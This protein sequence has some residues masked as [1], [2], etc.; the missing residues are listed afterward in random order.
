MTETSGRY[1]RNIG[2]VEICMQSHDIFLC[3]KILEEIRHNLLHKIKVPERTVASILALLKNR[4]N[5][6]EPSEIE[7]GLCRDECDRMVL[8]AAK[9]VSPRQ[10]WEL[11]KSAK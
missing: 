3:D 2:T 10:F 1:D 7:N 5:I 8:G 11:L 4:C 9:K 6:V